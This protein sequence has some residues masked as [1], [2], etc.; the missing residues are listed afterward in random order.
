MI[1]NIEIPIHLINE[2][3]DVIARTGYKKGGSDKYV[4][5][6]KELISQETN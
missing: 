4:K 6:L 5:H 1:A 2:K 3:G